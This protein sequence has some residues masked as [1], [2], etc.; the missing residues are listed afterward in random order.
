VLNQKSGLLGISGLSSD[1]RDILGGIQKGH[2]RAK[3]AFDIYVHRLRAAIGG[4]AAV[5]HG[6][7][8][9]VFTAGVGENSSEV[10]AAACSGLEFLGLKLDTEM[11][12]RPSLDQDISTADSRVRVLVIRAEEDWA[13]AAECWKLAHAAEQVGATGG[14]KAGP[15]LLNLQS[16]E[17]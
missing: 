9:L 16:R 4:M 10:R 5:L 17:A 6:I 3:L 11:N 8:A 14:Q 13:I 7:D 2:E 1:M 12:A 15:A